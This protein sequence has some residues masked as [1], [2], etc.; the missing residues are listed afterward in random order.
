MNRFLR[1]GEYAA[2]YL[3]AGLL[4]WAPYKLLLLAFAKHTNVWFEL[5]SIAI[6]L[7]TLLCTIIASV[8]LCFLALVIS[9][10][11][12]FQAKGRSFLI[13]LIVLI[14]VT[15]RL[16]FQ[17]YLLLFK[18]YLPTTKFY[19]SLASTICSLL[20]ITFRTYRFLDFHDNYV[21]T[22]IWRIL[23]RGD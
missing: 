1:Y 4:L 12:Q 16:N 14:V 8:I 5:G 18:V 11:N 21:D 23:K 9:S 2:F 15:Y 3:F 13:P 19:I 17:D 20:Y 7:L 22:S 10:L 6:V